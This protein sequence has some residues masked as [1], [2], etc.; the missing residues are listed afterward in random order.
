MT[1]RVEI[2]HEV[3]SIETIYPSREPIFYL[4]TDLAKALSTMTADWHIVE[5][6]TEDDDDDWDGDPDDDDSY[7]YYIEFANMDDATQFTL[8]WC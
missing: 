8:K 7:R 6:Q 4:R 1:F 3:L 2:S 5:E